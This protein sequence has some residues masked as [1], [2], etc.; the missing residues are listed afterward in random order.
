MTIAYDTFP[1]FVESFDAITD[2]EREKDFSKLADRLYRSI[3]RSESEQL[4]AQM[5]A[6]LG[7]DKPNRIANGGEDIPTVRQTLWS[8]DYEGQRVILENMRAFF[9]LYLD[10]KA[11]NIVEE[12]LEM[13]EEKED[14]ERPFVG[15]WS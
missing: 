12:M 13:L 15:S 1:T 8:V 2:A 4:K 3:K 6:Y 14:K 7:Y 9:A 10:D 11:V 5:L